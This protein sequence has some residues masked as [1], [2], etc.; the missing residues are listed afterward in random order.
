MSN[1]DTEVIFPLEG[2]DDPTTDD[3]P[4]LEDDSDTDGKWQLETPNFSQLFLSI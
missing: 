4:I 1:F 3:H 2:M